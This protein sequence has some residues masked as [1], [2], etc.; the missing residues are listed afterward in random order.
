LAK[1]G[2]VASLL[3]VMMI[4]DKYTRDETASLCSALRLVAAND[5]ICQEAADAGAVPVAH[6]ILDRAIAGETLNAQLARSVL[7]LLRQLASSDAV[8]AS[9]VSCGGLS[10]LRDA[11]RYSQEEGI[12]PWGSVAEPALGL[13]ANLALRS[14]DISKS[15]TENGCATGAV[16]LMKEMLKLRRAEMESAGNNGKSKSRVIAALRQGCMAMRNMSARCVEAREGILAA[17]GEA[18]VREAQRM[19]PAACQDVA[20]AALRDFGL[21]NYT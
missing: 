13:L 17:G 2:A 3:R 8:K 21:T 9:I 16:E 1:G 15:A 18:M 11:L 6:A 10:A 12:M 7:S 4:H 5:E 20:S 14:P 19:A